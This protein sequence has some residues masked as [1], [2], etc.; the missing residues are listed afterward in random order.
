[1][2][3]RAR[4]AAAA[5]R[6]R[7]PRR[8]A[9]GARVGDRPVVVKRL[10]APARTTRP[11]LSD[12]R[13]FAYWRRAADVVI[14][15]I[16]DAT[17]GLRS[18]LDAAVEEDDEGITIVEEWVED[19]ADSGL[20]VAHALGRFAGAELGAARWLARDQLRDRLGRV[21][22]RGGWPTLA[23]TT[24]ADV[25][26][27]LWR[28]REALLTR[29]TRWPRCRS[30]ATRRPRTCPAATATTWWRWTGRRSGT[31]RSARTSATTL[32]QRPRGVR[33][34]AGRLPDGPAGRPRRP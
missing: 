25:A 6:H 32:S 16:V 34:A 18:P 10:A 2:A 4:V 15:G 3:A 11:E 31:D 8:S 14:S 12:P 22:R 26:D 29:S 9:S 17:P 19:A 7:A 30:T 5:R 33:A 24:V 28:R 21:E 23:R 20:F 13:H 1:M 27:H